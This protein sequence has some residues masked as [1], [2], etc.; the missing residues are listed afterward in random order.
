MGS[1]PFCVGRRWV[2]LFDV[3]VGGAVRPAG[4]RMGPQV[5]S[6]PQQHQQQ[7]QLLVLQS[8]EARRQ[9]ETNDPT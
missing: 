9:D 3:A 2:A 4:G 6:T 8:Y 5:Y 1:I 7:L